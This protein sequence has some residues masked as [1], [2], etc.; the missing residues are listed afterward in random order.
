[1][2]GAS[3]GKKTSADPDQAKDVVQAMDDADGVKDPGPKLPIK[4]VKL[5]SLDSDKK[6]S[7]D[8]LVDSLVSPCG[9]A[10]SLRTSANTDAS[11]KRALYAARYVAYLL[12]DEYDE[13]EVKELYDIR[14]KDKKV[15]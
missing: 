10:H 13:S 15:Y 9:K 12:S 1:M 14:Y 2:V 5:D 6:A 3:C 8:K 4:G 11:C 7:F